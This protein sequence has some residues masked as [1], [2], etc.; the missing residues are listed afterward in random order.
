MEQYYSNIKTPSIV[1]YSILKNKTS[2][3]SITTML[4]TPTISLPN[5]LSIL[6]KGK[7]FKNHTIAASVVD[8]LNK[9][10][11]TSTATDLLLYLKHYLSLV[12]NDYNKDY[13]VK[14]I[15][16]IVFEELII[17]AGPDIYAFQTFYGIFNLLSLQKLSK[18]PQILKNFY[19]SLTLTDQKNRSGLFLILTTHKNKLLEML[20]VLAKDNPEH[21]K[22]IYTSLSIKTKKGNSALHILHKEQYI[23]N[24]NQIKNLLKPS[25]YLSFFSMFLSKHKTILKELN[26][27]QL[28]CLNCLDHKN[29]HL[30]QPINPLDRLEYLH[31]EPSGITIAQEESGLENKTLSTTSI[32]KQ[33]SYLSLT[34]VPHVNSQS[35]SSTSPPIMSGF[36]EAVASASTLENPST[37]FAQFPRIMEAADQPT[38]IQTNSSFV[39]SEYPSLPGTPSA[40]NQNSPEH[41]P[42][43][44]QRLSPPQQI[45]NSLLFK[46]GP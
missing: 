44:L 37:F 29:K 31:Q 8:L 38:I 12:V 23:K 40:S 32:E 46:V 19:E 22:D 41:S 20:I 25:F 18:N 35:F 10:T 27:I 17:A 36:T 34:N 43:N 2:F 24:F 21:I 26:E 13:I 1:N 15:V 45:H 5:R 30:D 6:L 3:K 28:H 14:K 4:N 11:Q 39:E 42:S 9:H 7:S 33:L 16:E